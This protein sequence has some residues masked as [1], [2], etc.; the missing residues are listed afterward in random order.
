L[1]NSDVKIQISVDAKTGQLKVLNKDLNQLDTNTKTNQTSLEALKGKMGGLN[2]ALA[3][4]T[5]ST[6]AFIKSGIDLNAQAESTTIAI[7]ALISANSQNIS[8]TGKALSTIEKYNLANE[9]TTEVMK[10]LKKIN[11]ETSQTLT[12]T[13][14]TFKAIYGSVVNV[15]GSME[16]TIELTKLFAQSASASGVEFNSFLSIVDGVAD[17]SYDANSEYGRFLK[18]IGLT[19]EAIK[20]SN[21]KI[22]LLKDKLKDFGAVGKIVQNSF[23]GIKSNLQ[24]TWD[25]L[26]Q[27]ATQPIFEEFKTS[28]IDVNDYLSTNSKDLTQSFLKSYYAIKPIFH[29]IQNGFGLIGLA[30]DTFK[31]SITQWANYF[32]YQGL[33]V[34]KFFQESLKDI[35]SLGL[36][37]SSSWNDLLPDFAPKSLKIDTKDFEQSISQSDEKIKAFDISMNNLILEN[38]EL[39]KSLINSREAFVKNQKEINFDGYEEYTKKAKESSK[40]IIK[41]KLG[42]LKVQKKVSDEIKDFIKDEQKANRTAYEQAVWLRNEELKKYGSNKKAK[43]LIEK[44]FN[45]TIEDLNKKELDNYNKTQKEQLDIAEEKHKEELKSYEKLQ[46][47]KQKANKEFFNNDTATLNSMSKNWSISMQTIS[48]NY[49]LTNAKMQEYMTSFVGSMESSLSGS[50]SKGLKGEFDSASDFFKDFGKSVLNTVIDMASKVAAQQLVLSIVGNNGDGLLS[51]IF[52]IMGFADGTVWGDGKYGVVGGTSPF[53]GDDFRN[54]TIPALISSG[55]AVIPRTK[56][57]ANRPII[58]Q[59]LS[60]QTVSVQKYAYGNLAYDEHNQPYSKDDGLYRFFS[61]GGFIKK[62]MSPVTDVIK[63]V[64]E[65]TTDNVVQP[66]MKPVAKTI[67]DSI[68][69]VK[70]SAFK[71]LGTLMEN[72]ALSWLG[73]AAIAI[74]APQ[75]IPAM[76]KADLISAGITLGTGGDLGDMLA[77][78]GVSGLVAAGTGALFGDIPKTDLTALETLNKFGTDL[79]VD[80]ANTWTSAKENFSE[81]FGTASDNVASGTNSITDF[82]DTKNIIYDNPT[83][84]MIKNLGLT[85]HGG[86]WYGSETWID[87]TWDGLQSFGDTIVKWGAENLATVKEYVA[88]P[89]KLYELMQTYIQTAFDSLMSSISNLVSHPEIFGAFAGAMSQNL[90]AKDGKYPAN[91]TVSLMTDANTGPIEQ[92]LNNFR[93]FSTGGYTGFGRD[94]EIAGI[95]HKNEVVFNSRDVQR[96]GGV[97]NVENIRKG[98]SNNYDFKKLENKLDQLIEYTYALLV[99]AK[100]KSVDKK[101]NDYK[102]YNNI[103]GG[104]NQDSTIS[105]KFEQVNTMFATISTQ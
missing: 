20:N 32:E 51:K 63:S 92:N 101:L 15:G 17:G 37:M 48:D 97:A 105:E 57:E 40:E 28:M 76:L 42:E 86:T 35:N 94:D 16:D 27:T 33:R 95:V 2:V 13:T 47:E 19:P 75:F 91:T 25:D 100:E 67:A 80:L 61:F 77:G 56:V 38:A 53:R 24:N 103:S 69:W 34:V 1:S 29:L 59:I 5:A 60:G 70:D 22:Q 26:R 66:V 52:N 84:D 87:R 11:L 6:G 78:A 21:D 104:I 58:E 8:T 54:D 41:S 46:D 102:I 23:D 72:P 31:P 83:S 98:N 99:D 44:K 62:I 9:Q 88:D 71:V 39:E 3:A 81:F 68:D 18:T 89:S 90:L 79:S 36:D 96:H 74:M 45:R 14:D 43:E 30:I 50:I 93:G 82:F 85:N 55:E 7:N 64:G 49:R 10:D 12:Q 73:Q 4:A 65:F